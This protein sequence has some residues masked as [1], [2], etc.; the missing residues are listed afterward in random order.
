MGQVQLHC[1][2]LASWTYATL[3]DQFC[4]LVYTTAELYFFSCS[5][6]TH[7][8]DPWKQCIP[9]PNNWVY[10]WLLAALPNFIRLV[11]SIKRYIDSRLYIHLIN[12]SA[13]RFL[14][15][16]AEVSTGRQVFIQYS[17]LLSVL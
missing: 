10:Y 3:S 17:G 8:N 7:F 12:V 2:D 11:Q 9:R 6:I 5:Y 1:T 4:S 16:T 13:P 15:H 14:C